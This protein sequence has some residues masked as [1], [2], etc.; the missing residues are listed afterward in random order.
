[1]MDELNHELTSANRMNTLTKIWL[2]HIMSFVTCDNGASL[3]HG[4]YY[5]LRIN[6]NTTLNLVHGCRCSYHC[7]GL[8][9]ASYTFD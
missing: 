7:L 3:N 5:D 9:C 2:L 8:E 1:M 6:I 4:N